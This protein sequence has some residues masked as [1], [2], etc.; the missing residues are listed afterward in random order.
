MEDFSLCENI[1]KDIINSLSAH[2]VILDKE[3]FILETNQAWREF[4]T[5]NGMPPSFVWK[6]VN[7]LAI[8]DK[9]ASACVDVQDV[10]NGIRRVIKGEE[11]QYFTRYPCHSTEE[12]RWYTMR[13]V[14]LRSTGLPKIIVTH[15]EITPIMQAQEALISKEQELS[16]Q[17]QQLEEA[18]IALKVLLQHKEQDRVKNEEQILTNVVS[19]V[20]PYMEK[21]RMSSLSGHQLG[22][23][24]IIE[25]NL[26]EIISPFLSRLTAIHRL[27][28]PQEIKVASLVRAGK[29]SKEIAAA[30][31]VSVSA[32][33]FHRKKLRKKLGLSNTSSNLRTYLLALH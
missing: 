2:I 32:V 25:N 23:L 22:L 31:A 1:Y 30:L 28:T 19:L 33:D 6:G 21:L 7:Y 4:A 18:N 17:K 8:C 29:T 26:Q 14:G 12:K 15:E 5:K 20:M 9:A 3:G 11:K 13:V 24:D 27:L 10:A 16:A